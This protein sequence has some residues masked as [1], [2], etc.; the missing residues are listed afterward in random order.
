MFC[1]FFCFFVLNHHCNKIYVAFL[2]GY[3]ASR[4]S[5]SENFSETA[6][7]KFA[8]VCWFHGRRSPNQMITWFTQLPTFSG[9]SLSHVSRFGMTNMKIKGHRGSFGRN[10]LC[11]SPS[12]STFASPFLPRPSVTALCF[13]NGTRQEC[14]FNDDKGRIRQGRS[15][16]TDRWRDS[17][18][19]FASEMVADNVYVPLIQSISW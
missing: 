10:T 1:C 19:S 17:Y 16:R 8:I 18:N 13:L 9:F 7:P 5:A 15:W 2:L 14:E 4:R 3:L 12:P 6:C 11:L